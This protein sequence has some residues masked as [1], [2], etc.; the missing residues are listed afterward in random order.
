MP[1]LTLCQLPN[2]Y[3]TTNKSWPALP[4]NRDCPARKLCGTTTKY[5]ACRDGG[6]GADRCDDATEGWCD[7]G[8]DFDYCGSRVRCPKGS[9]ARAGLTGG[10]EICSGYKDGPVNVCVLCAK[11][12]YKGKDSN[13][14][15]RLGLCEPCAP[16]KYADAQGST[17]CKLCP[18]GTYSD[19]PQSTSVKICFQCG[20]G[21]Y[22]A[23]EGASSSTTCIACEAD[24]SSASET[25]SNNVERQSRWTTTTLGGAYD[26]TNACVC[27]KG[28]Y[29]A[30]VAGRDHQ[31]SVA[32]SPFTCVACP[33]QGADC[34]EAG[35]TIATL[36][37]S[38]GFWRVDGNSSAILA[39]PVK[40]SCIS[41]SAPTNTT[42]NNS[43]YTYC[44]VGH[45][46]PLCAVCAPG[47]HRRSSRSLC[48]PCG[49][50]SAGSIV[51]ALVVAL[52]TLVV[53]WLY[54]F[55]S[56]KASGGAMRTVINA[57]QSLSVI[58]M[59]GGTEWP[60]EVLDVQ[61]WVLDVV[62]LDVISLASPTCAGYRMDFFSRFVALLVGV[63]TVI[64]VPWLVSYLR[65]LLGKKDGEWWAKAKEQR[66]HD[67]AMVILL[68]YT[69]V[70]AQ[71]FYFFR[72]QTIVES[73]DKSTSYL[74]ADFSVTCYDGKWTGQA[75]FVVLVL[76]VFSL[77][78]PVANAYTLWRWRKR[79]EDDA[80]AKRLLGMM[81]LMYN[82]RTY[83]MESI[84]ILFKLLLLCA[85]T[86]LPADGQLQKTAMFLVCAAQILTHGKLLP[87]RKPADNAFQYCG[88]ALAF[89]P[90]FMGIPLSYTKMAR[91]EASL[92]L[93]GP[94]RDK[95]D[96]NFERTLDVLKTITN[97]GLVGVVIA[98]A[99]V[100]VYQY[101]QKFVGPTAAALSVRRSSVRGRLWR[102]V[103]SRGK[104][105]GGGGVELSVAGTTDQEASRDQSRC[106]SHRSGLPPLRPPTA[107]DSGGSSSGSLGGR[108]SSGDFAAA[109]A[110]ALGQC[111]EEEQEEGK[112]TGRADPLFDKSDPFSEPPAR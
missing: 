46:G 96:D 78:V 110:R 1:A 56:R 15:E 30:R 84:N 34:S 92:R 109:A 71:A 36:P 32:A 40:R 52:A 74:V 39:C 101:R 107:T 98:Y 38:E 77:G 4:N 6:P 29:R 33:S 17:A 18:A 62:N 43:R 93:V 89:V 26:A 9:E 73:K 90:A 5:R 54:L 58:L 108:A 102:R 37:V 10:M 83:F 111:E 13:D 44:R 81:Y 65:C 105:S 20:A 7:L 51:L 53:V 42:N 88:L 66:L 28:T 69:T 27:Q 91:A 60:K 72:C 104:S 48:G 80:G 76:V 57:S 14:T 8:T 87:F 41:S 85:L 97:V 25:Y 3:I 82:P 50:N 64:G 55:L 47:Y 63:G 95:V 100:G 106:D 112:K 45:E 99:V 23:T 70:T 35:I 21:R 2:N 61:R 94:E 67:T 31:D 11:G 75:V 103:V 79:L 16:G 59:T 24:A 68:V 22:S 19:V 49:N 12:W 86:L